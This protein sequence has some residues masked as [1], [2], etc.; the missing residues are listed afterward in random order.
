MH[1]GN[2]VDKSR[3]F[4]VFYGELK[5]AP[6]IS[7]CLVTMECKLVRTVEFEH[8]ELHV[9]EVISVYVDKS[10]MTGNKANMKKVNPLMCNGGPPATYWKIGD[11][12]AKAYDVGKSYKPNDTRAVSS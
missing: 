4:E 9:G 3:V 5:K 10:L 8:N 12:I 1:S 6:M 7:E 11:Q 2:N